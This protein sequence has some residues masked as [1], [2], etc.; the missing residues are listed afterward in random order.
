MPNRIIKES[1]CTSCENDS[2][3]PEQEVFFYRLIVNCDD[4]GRMDARLPVLRAKCYPLRVDKVK[5]KDVRGWLEA[6][7]EQKLIFLYSVEGKPYLQ[8]VTWNKHQQIRAQKSKYPDPCEGVISSD[9]NGNQEQSNVP[10][11]QSNP[12]QSSMCAYSKIFEAFWSDY[13]R[14]VEKKAAFKCWNTR[15]REGYKPEE[16]ILAAKNYAKECKAKGTEQSYIKHPKTFLGPNKP[17][18]EYLELSDSSDSR[19]LAPYHRKIGGV[20]NGQDPTT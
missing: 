14:K 17:F 11:I 13:P 16:L 4:Y 7:S 8:M 19:P 1:I 12:I 10:V 3:T 5:D 15:L 18:E 6:L 20:V 9:I 2:L